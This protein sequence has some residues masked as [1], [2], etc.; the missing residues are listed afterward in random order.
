MSLVVQGLCPPT[1]RGP[2]YSMGPASPSSETCS[3]SSASTPLQYYKSNLK[4]NLV[5]KFKKYIF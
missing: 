5:V 4:S 3:T 2:T 1:L